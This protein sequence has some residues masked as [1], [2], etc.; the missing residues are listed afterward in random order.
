MP[1]ADVNDRTDFEDADRGL[2][3]SLKPCLIRGADGA[4]IWN[5]DACGFLAGA[6]PDTGTLTKA[7]L[8][9]VLGGSGLEGLD[10]E[11][12]AALLDRFVS[13]ID[14][15]SPDFAIVTP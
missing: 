4:E 13:Y 6:C 2:L 15:A 14:S 1:E 12:D 5:N 8:L 7:G 9:G 10:A 3:G 11:G